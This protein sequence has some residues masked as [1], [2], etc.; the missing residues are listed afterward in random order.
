[1]SAGSIGG[2][3]GTRAP[4]VVNKE[5]ME[6]GGA[7]DCDAASRAPLLADSS[8]SEGHVEGREKSRG[9]EVQDKA[10]VKRSPLSSLSTQSS[11]CPDTRPGR[12]GVSREEHTTVDLSFA[13]TSRHGTSPW[14]SAVCRQGGTSVAN[15]NAGIQ[16]LVGSSGTATHTIPVC[17]QSWVHCREHRPRQRAC[18][19]SLALTLVQQKSKTVEGCVPPCPG[20]VLSSQEQLQPLPPLSTIT[21]NLA[22]VLQQKDEIMLSI[23]DVI[24]SSCD[25]DDLLAELSYYEKL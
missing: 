25:T 24:V 11:R 2:V 4:D 16:P 18:K 6:N 22:E 8:C 15:T 23:D 10:R 1:M 5:N 17:S 13:G 3:G 12:P 21:D 7:E 9:G 20:A 14:P 19:E